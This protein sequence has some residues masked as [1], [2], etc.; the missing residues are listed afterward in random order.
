MSLLLT[1]F[2]M[3]VSLSEIKEEQKYQ[4]MVESMTKRFGYDTAMHSLAPGQSQPRNAMIAKVANEGRARRMNVMQGGD[5]AQA[6]V[7]EHPRVRIIRPG[8]KTN[9]GTV[10]FFDESSAELTDARQTG[11]RSKSVAC[12]HRTTTEDRNPR[13]YFAETAPRKCGLQEPLGTGL[14]TVLE[15]VSVPDHKN[16]NRTPTDP[17][18]GRRARMSRCTWAPIPSAQ[19]ENP[20][21]EVF[22]LDEVVSDLMGTKEEQETAVHGWRSSLIVAQ[23]AMRP[24]R[25]QLAGNDAMADNEHTN[26][27]RKPGTSMLG[28]LLIAGFMGAVVVAECLFAYFWLPSADEVAAQVELVAKDAKSSRGRQIRKTGKQRKQRGN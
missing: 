1:F 20:R 11:T 24:R 21:V 27:E 19:R 17:H 12:V 9:V 7:G 8:E 10:I 4:A 15:Y 5:K 25:G 23:V 26:D 13:T 16:G 28:R 14:P 22:M 18:L 6:P 2:I 3:L